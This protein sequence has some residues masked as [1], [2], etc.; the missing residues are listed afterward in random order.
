[1]AML[2]ITRL[3]KSYGNIIEHPRTQS[4]AIAGR[5]ATQ[6]IPPLA[7]RSACANSR[8][9]FSWG[10]DGSVSAHPARTTSLNV[11]MFEIEKTL[12]NPP[13]I[14][15]KLNL[16]NHPISSI[17][18]YIYTVSRIRSQIKS[19]FYAI[20]WPMVCLKTLANPIRN[21]AFLRW[22]NH[23]KGK[24]PASHD[25]QMAILYYINIQ[26]YSVIFPMMFHDVSRLFESC[27][28]FLSKEVKKSNFGQYGQMKSRDGKGQGEEKD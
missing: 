1:M 25:L 16:Q 15:S 27:C 24:P 7:S 10:L 20:R 4:I 19:T 2:V 21:G 28:M 14:G 26:Q 12:L 3:G 13:R 11:G 22:E 17:Y 6:S 8:D 23:R 9:I 18:I 5:V